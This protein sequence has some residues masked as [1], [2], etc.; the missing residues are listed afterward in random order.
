MAHFT[1]IGLGRFGLT[2][3]TELI[4]MGHTVT[5]I[6]KDEKIIEQYADVLTQTLTCDAADERALE[7]LNLCQSEAVLVAI[8]EDMEASLL[9]TLHIK[10][11]GV[12]DI[13]VKA[14]TSAH[15]TILSKLGVTRIIHPEEEM[16]ARVAQALHYPMVSD[17]IGIGHSTYIVSVNLSAVF[18]SCS[19]NQLLE[20][21]DAFINC[22][23]VKR[24]KE[25]FTALNGDFVLI[26]GDIV[27]LCGTRNALVRIA[28]RLK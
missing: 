9:C 7:E 16:G 14:N 15:H 20:G 1:V 27:I 18:T 13:W 17:Y 23:L 11:L 8:G 2:A 25:I 21:F 26:A 4:H 5:G 10:N 3:S 12:Q 19:I 22:L 6:D 24:N 28:P